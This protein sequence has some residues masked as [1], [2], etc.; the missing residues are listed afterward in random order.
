[1]FIV[2]PDDV[3]DV[4]KVGPESMLR[5][6]EAVYGLVSTPKKWWDC[7]KRSLLNHGCTS[8][9]LGPCAFVLIKQNRV[10]G[11]AGI[12]VDDLL[13]GGDDVFDRTILEVKGEFDVGAWDVGAK[14]F[15][16]AQLKQM[17]NHEIMVDME[18]YKHQLQE[19]EV[20]K[21]DE[22]KP[23][24]FLSAKEVA[25]LPLW[26]LRQWMAGLI[27]AVHSFPST[28]RR[29]DRMMQPLRTC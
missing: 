22:I 18:H 6:C 8:C 27:T 11:V 24:R 5:R 28:S 21:S 26:P 13:A 19:I 14:R 3:P 4:P 9:A 23:E 7:S 1:M 2:P 12:D 10:R 20:S 15:K 17:A 25:R 29:G 16:A